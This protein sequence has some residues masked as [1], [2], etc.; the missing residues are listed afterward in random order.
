MSRFREAVDQLRPEGEIA[1]AAASIDPEGARAALA[2]SEGALIVEL[3]RAAPRGAEGEFGP[4]PEAPIFA[5]VG[6]E[7]ALTLASA[8]SKATSARATGVSLRCEER[9]W[10][11]G[12][13]SYRKCAA[14]IVV[15]L[16]GAD[17]PALTFACGVADDE[18]AARAELGPLASALAH[19][20]GVPLEG[21]DAAAE[22]PAIG[23]AALTTDEAARFSLGFEG[24][25][26]VLRDRESD[27]PRAGAGRNKIIAAAC[28]VPALVSLSLFA[29]QLRAYLADPSAGVGLVLGPLALGLVLG[30]AAYAFFEIA[31]FAEKYSAESEP[32][33]WFFDDRIVVAPWVSRGGAVDT[34]EGGRFG[35][36]IRTSEVTGTSIQARDERSAVV[37][38]SAHGPFDVLLTADPASAAHLASLLERT[39]RSVASPEKK[40]TALLRAQERRDKRV[41]AAEA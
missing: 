14:E 18:R 41:R 3:S 38:E 25:H 24:P 19:R 32:L 16:E 36:A 23:D 29:W 34:R 17:D 11:T 6:A 2:S 35:T 26:L 7:G 13:S 28:L 31:R 27:G 9:A 33:A 21:V 37:L 22:S 4:L 39:I 8:S 20:L 5:L 10:G 1:L 12:P 30:V 40:R 15:T